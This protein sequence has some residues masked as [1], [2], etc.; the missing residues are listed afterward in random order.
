MRGTDQLKDSKDIENQSSEVAVKS[1]LRYVQINGTAPSAKVDADSK[2]ARC[3]FGHFGAEAAKNGGHIKVPENIRTF[4]GH[5]GKVEP[6][7][8]GD[9]T[10]LNWDEHE[11]EDDH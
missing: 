10:Q 11:L 4:T 9:P 5:D 6:L 1:Q 3:L 8:L 7:F 2:L